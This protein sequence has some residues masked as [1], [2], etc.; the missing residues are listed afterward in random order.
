MKFYDL[1][2]HHFAVDQRFNSTILDG[3]T[4]VLDDE[5]PEDKE[6]PPT[7]QLHHPMHHPVMNPS[8]QN[9]M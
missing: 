4:N 9:Q 7:A 2:F 1:F 5:I 3:G 6:I 8:D